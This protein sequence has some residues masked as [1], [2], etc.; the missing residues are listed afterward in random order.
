MDFSREELPITSFFARTGNNKKKENL[1]PTRAAGKRKRDVVE[2]EADSK[3]TKNGKEKRAISPKPATSLDRSS[4]KK[5]VYGTSRASMSKG[6]QPSQKDIRSSRPHAPPLPEILD[7][8]TPS[9]DRKSDPGPSKRRRV[10]QSALSGHTSAPGIR[11]HVIGQVFPTPP[12]TSQSMKNTR[13]IPMIPTSSTSEFRNQPNATGQ[14][15]TPGTSVDRPIIRPRPSHL[16]KVVF[17]RTPASPLAARKGVVDIRLLLSSPL[18]PCPSDEHLL[19]H[20]DVIGR[21]HADV[22]QA[23]LDVAPRGHDDVGSLSFTQ[24]GNSN[25]V[26]DDDPFAAPAAG[27]IVPPSQPLHLPLPLPSLSHSSLI[28]NAGASTKTSPNFAV[29]SLPSHVLQSHTTEPRHPATNTNPTS[30]RAVV[31]SSQS[32]SLLPSA[33]SPRRMKYLSETVIASSQSQALLPFMNSPRRMERLF[34]PDAENYG[35]LIEASQIV[36]SSQSQ[37]EKELKMSMRPSQIGLFVLPSPA[38]SAS[39]RVHDLDV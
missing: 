4:L 36:G 22:A 35:H 33:D 39:Q 2:V 14:L 27:I 21:S 10:E 13:K 30:P 23:L 11:S 16:S 6:K 8:T 3:L 24:E 9:P 38:E 31:E 15:P 26:V 18:S 32:Q 7:L 5:Q 29:P 34:S 17:S 12:L 20:D 19:N 1:P 25:G 37:I 28:A